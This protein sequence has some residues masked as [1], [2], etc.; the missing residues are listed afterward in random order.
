MIQKSSEG[1]GYGPQVFS[2][3]GE[4]LRQ[5]ELPEQGTQ[6]G[7]GPWGTSPA[8]IRST[9]LVACGWGGGLWQPL[10]TLPAEL[11]AQGWRRA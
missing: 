9:P 10:A 2:S 11:E 8:H 6:W 5:Q 7:H 3:G 4:L 1:L